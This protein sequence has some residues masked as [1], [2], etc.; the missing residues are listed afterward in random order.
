MKDYLQYYLKS[1]L[2]GIKR[3]AYFSKSFILE[4]GADIINII[5]A[6]LFYQILYLNVGKGLGIPISD[7]FILVLSVKLTGDLYNLFFGTGVQSLPY[8][9]QYGTLDGLLIKPFNIFFLMY[10]SKLNWKCLANLIIDIFLFMILITK[11]AIDISLVS[12]LSYLAMICFATLIFTAFNIL[13]YL[14]SIIF[15]RL[16]A[17]ISLISSFFS[18]ST[19]PTA[20]FRNKILRWVFTYLIPVIV[21]GNFPLMAIRGEQKGSLFLIVIIITLLFSYLAYWGTISMLKH[22][23]S[24]SS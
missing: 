6:L 13:I 2:L 14:G 4:I 12:V 19:F 20:I 8:H 24:A 23:K 22:Y 15:V 21:I 18:L 9:I 11:Y 7:L 5:F 16:D 3:I 10:L 17:F 1:N